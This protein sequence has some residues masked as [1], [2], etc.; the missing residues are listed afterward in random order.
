MDAGTRMQTPAAAG[1][2]DDLVVKLGRPPGA[3][4]DPTLTSSPLLAAVG[5]AGT[6]HIYGDTADA[7][8]LAALIRT[9]DG[10]IVREVDGNTA[11]QPL[12]HKVIARYL[13][14]GDPAGWARQL[15][16]QQPALTP[17]ALSPLV[18]AIVCGRIGNDAA[19]AFGA[20]RNWEVSLQLHMGL[21]RDAEAAKRVGRYLRHM[22]PSGVVKVP[23]T[24][25]YPHCF[26][27]A[28]DLERE[29]IPVNFTSTFS[30]RQVVVAAL[31]ADVTLTN[32]F[33]GRI[34]QGMQAALLGEHVDLEAQRVLR[35]LRRDVGVKT[36]LIVASVREWQTFV[37]VAGCDVF[38]APLDAIRGLLTQTEVPADAVRSQLD[39]SYADRLGIADDVLR[40]L[41]KERIARLYHVEPELIQFLTE[42]RASKDYQSLRDG[43]QLFKRFDAAGFGDVFYAP[44]AAEWTELRKNKLPVLGAPLTNRLPLDTLYTLLADADF[45]KYQE[46]MDRMIAERIG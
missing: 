36:L 28:R 29:G 32:I 31:L 13:D 46:D 16:E 42:L 15:R 17:D 43:D 38:T 26:L 18:Y 37:Y 44:S 30:A 11:N 39:T 8:D 24:P 27:V 34:N 3:V 7:T 4:A 19:R 25:Q 14:G 9:H 41:G 23:F 21:S 6:T 5:R 40:A 2:F 1:T 12:V 10:A 33:M 22:V 45:D 35:K 20:G